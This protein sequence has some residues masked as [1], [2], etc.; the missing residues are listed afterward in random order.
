M[1]HLSCHSPSNAFITQK[2]KSWDTFKLF[3]VLT[4]FTTYEEL[5]LFQDDRDG[6]YK[7]HDGSK[8]FKRNSI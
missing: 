4:D 6:R 8:S 3:F 5:L 7:L 1:N 2:N